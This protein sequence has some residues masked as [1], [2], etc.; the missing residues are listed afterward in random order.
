MGMLPVVDA[1]SENMN[2]NA[3]AVP[4][5]E[6]DNSHAANEN[7]LEYNKMFM[8]EPVSGQHS[9][10]QPADDDQKERPSTGVCSSTE[11][12]NMMSGNTM[13]SS[14]SYL[15]VG[16]LGE[17]SSNSFGV[18]PTTPRTSSTSSPSIFVQPMLNALP[19]LLTT[20]VP[21]FNASNIPANQVQFPLMQPMPMA[22]CAGMPVLPGPNAAQVP[23]TPYYM[24]LMPLPQ[25]V[26]QPGHHQ[27]LFTAGYPGA[28]MFQHQQQMQFPAS[29]ISVNAPAVPVLLPPSHAEAEQV[30]QQ[31]LP[32]ADTEEEAICGRGA[33]G[34]QGETG[35]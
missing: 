26:G 22:G 23:T 13:A 6:N 2:I 34:N 18:E 11:I 15:R 10:Q 16:P 28:W 24:P 1:V 14:E 25:A 3:T 21:S 12:K 35:D 29:P 5:N 17:R 33:A 30:I 32:P 7:L 20:S 31:S 19:S 4:A 8:Q 9:E 27:G